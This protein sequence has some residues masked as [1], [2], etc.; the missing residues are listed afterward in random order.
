[1]FPYLPHTADEIRQMLD[2]LGLESMEDLFSDIPAGLRLRGPLNIP[3]GRSEYEVYSSMKRLAAKSRTDFVSFLGGGSYDHFIPATVRH[4]ISRSEF[5]TSYTPYQAEISQGFLQAIF[6]FQT[7]IC[8][9]TSLA[10]SNASLYDGHTAASEAA[11]VALNKARGA[12]KI[13]YSETIH[14]HTKE[15]LH[16]HFTGNGIVLERIEQRDGITSF[17]DMKKKLSGQVAAVIV[18]TPNFYGYL[19][20]YSGFA[21][22]IHAQGAFFVVSSNP[23][24]LGFLRSPG[25]WGADIAIGDTQPCG[26]PSFF[27]G[28]SVG[29]IAAT[30]ELL[31]KM[32]GRIV[33]QSL[34]ADGRRAFLLTLQAREQHIKRERATSNICSNQALAALA[35]AVYLATLGKQGLVELSQQNAQKAHYLY[36]RLVAEL[37]VEPLHRQPFF[38]E[39]SLRLNKDPYQV[40]RSMQEEGFLAGIALERFSPAHLKGAISIAVT[41]KRSRQEMDRY[42][43]TLSRILQ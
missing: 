8:Q 1:M 21:E 9:L 40:I 32:P 20:D 4:I 10:V 12:D 27:G 18:Q 22:L 11:T 33:G 39:F 24:S 13:L 36:E 2:E 30:S 23:L 41:E 29:Y 25:E 7:M 26:L 35:T 31:R 17:Q 16:T 37:P 43:A 38:N 5:Y 3:V 34:D 19:E 15:V 42:V 14:P 28:P 6:E